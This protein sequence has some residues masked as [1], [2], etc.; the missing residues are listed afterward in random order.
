MT[1]YSVFYMKP[2]WFEKPCGASSFACKPEVLQAL[3]VCEQNHR[4]GGDWLNF[5]PRCRRL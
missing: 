2:E 3:K 4:I 1:K 5:T